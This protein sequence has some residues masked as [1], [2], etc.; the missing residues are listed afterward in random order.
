MRCLRRQSKTRQHV[1]SL[2]AGLCLGQPF[3][4]QAKGHV[5]LHIEVRKERKVLKHQGKAAPLGRPGGH[6]LPVPPDAA[7]VGL[8][9]P[10]HNLEQ[11]TFA[12]ARRPQQSHN[13]TRRHAQVDAGK[14]GASLKI[15][16]KVS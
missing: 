10:S 15:F 2:G 14:Q 12:T 5:V 3:L 16:G 4:H 6:V 8:L 13:F 1:R 11:G 7:L 9:Q